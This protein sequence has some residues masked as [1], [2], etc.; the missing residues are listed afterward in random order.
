MM[1]DGHS[2]GISL[3]FHSL[4]PMSFSNKVILDP[5][6]LDLDLRMVCLLVALSKG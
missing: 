6:F 3:I 2:L 5:I 4:L 1:V